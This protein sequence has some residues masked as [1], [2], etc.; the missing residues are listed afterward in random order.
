MRSNLFQRVKHAISGLNNLFS[1]GLYGLYLESQFAITD[2]K[3]N[4]FNIN[5]W[6]KTTAI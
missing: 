1:F 2:I 4:T 3:Y 6:M 5:E